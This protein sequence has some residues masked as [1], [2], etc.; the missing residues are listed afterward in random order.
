MEKISI[1]EV[2]KHFPLI[3]LS[4]TKLGNY[5]AFVFEKRIPKYPYYDPD[6][7]AI[8]DNFT[9]RISTSRDIKKAVTAIIG[10][11][12][13]SEFSGHVYGLLKIPKDHM[14]T[15]EHKKTYCNPRLD[16]YRNGQYVK[17]GENED[18]KKHWRLNEWLKFRKHHKPL[19]PNTGDDILNDRALDGYRDDF[20]GCVPDDNEEY[21]VTTDTVFYY[22]GAYHSGD[23]FLTASEFYQKLLTILNESPKKVANEALLTQF[24]LSEL[25]LMASH[26]KSPIR[27][28]LMKKMHRTL[29]PFEL[30]PKEKYLAVKRAIEN[31]QSSS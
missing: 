20:Y 6:G 31:R 8:E 7:N 11:H 14:S 24:T 29:E 16:Y 10:D 17:Y 21:W 25:K 13:D 5:D 9:P 19:P 27:D 15:T 3:H 30:S 28:K 2:K 18:L 26:D 1:D 4:Y 23:D 22:L 12:G